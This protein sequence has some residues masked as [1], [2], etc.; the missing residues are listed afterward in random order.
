MVVILYFKERIRRERQQEQA[1]RERILA[2]IAADRAELAN[3]AAMAVEVSSTTPTTASI[4]TITPEQSHHVAVEETRLQIRLPGG[5]IRIKDFPIIEPLTTV[6]SYVREELLAST[7]I[8]EFT[9][10]T[11]YPRR[12]FKIEDELLSLNDLKLVPNAVLL[13]L[14]SN[15]VNCVVRSRNNVMNILTSVIWAILTPAA[16]AFDYINKHGFQRLRARF[17]QIFANMSWRRPIQAP[18]TPQGGE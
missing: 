11:S 16:V 8:R 1:T 13:V 7:S 15:Q 2:Q 3:R 14:G 10:A 5:I 9:L 17:A 6:R 18:E 12:E 4:A